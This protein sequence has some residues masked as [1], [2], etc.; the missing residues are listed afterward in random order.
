[1]TV[2]TQLALR[3]GPVHMSA[4]MAGNDLAGPFICGSGHQA[5]KRLFGKGTHVQMG[6]SWLG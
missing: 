6:V 4:R 1:M 3:R 2:M 5:G